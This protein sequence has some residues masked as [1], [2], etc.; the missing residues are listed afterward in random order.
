MAYKTDHELYDITQINLADDHAVQ[1]IDVLAS[2]SLDGET[3]ML[4]DEAFA[5]GFDSVEEYLAA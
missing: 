1:M 4:L 2:S 5:A 3:Q